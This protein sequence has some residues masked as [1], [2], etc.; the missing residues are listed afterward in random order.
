MQDCDQDRVHERF[1]ETAGTKNREL[2]S[3]F[4]SAGATASRLATPV[5]NSFHTF[6]LQGASPM[7]TRR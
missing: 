6:S 5:R 7:L 4:D 1:A 2:I 3:Y